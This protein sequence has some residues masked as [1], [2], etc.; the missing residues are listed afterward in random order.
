MIQFESSEVVLKKINEL[1]AQG[2]DKIHLPGGTS[3]DGSYYAGAVVALYDK[4][5]KEIYFL[6]VPYNSNF[7]FNGENSHNKKFGEIPE[8]TVIRELL[9]E[10]GLHTNPENLKLIWDSSIPDNRSGK[11]GEFHLKFVYLVTDFTGNIFDFPG[12]NP[13]DRETAAPLWIPSSLFFKLIFGGHIK[14]VEKAIE[15]LSMQSREYAY[16]LMNL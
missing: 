8:Q 15:E 6:G 14:A 12:P 7:H 11:K 5:T 1:K 4:I 10:T 16:I 2:F 9:E 3:K 13:I